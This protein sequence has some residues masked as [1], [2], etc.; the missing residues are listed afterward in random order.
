MERGLDKENIVYYFFL[1]V[2]QAVLM[3]GYQFFCAVIKVSKTVERD[4]TDY[5]L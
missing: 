5:R 1:V 3:R 2:S 4:V